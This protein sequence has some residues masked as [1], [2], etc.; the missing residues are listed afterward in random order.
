MAYLGSGSGGSRPVRRGAS[1]DD[2]RDTRIGYLLGFVGGAVAVAVFVAAALTFGWADDLQRR[3]RHFDVTRTVSDL[4][5]EGDKKASD[6]GGVIGNIT[7][8]VSNQRSVS[9]GRLQDASRAVGDAAGAQVPA[10]RR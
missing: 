10:P 2:R 4:T 8:A 7:G 9:G 3:W 1:W 5:A 6:L